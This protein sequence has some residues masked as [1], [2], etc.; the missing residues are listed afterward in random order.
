MIS[1][2]LH[3]G[4]VWPLMSLFL[5]EQGV[6]EGEIGLISGA[7]A[8]APLLLWPAYTW[9]F[10]R[11][12]AVGTVALGTVLSLACIALFFWLG[13]GWWSFVFRFG[14]GVGR[15]L[16]WVATE[17]WVNHIAQNHDRGRAIA[18]YSSGWAVGMVVGPAL[19]SL[20]GD[21]GSLPVVACVISTL[22][23]VL[24]LLIFGR[25]YA[26]TL[27]HEDTPDQSNQQ[28]PTERAAK[29][30]HLADLV[31]LLRY[32]PV[33]FLAA[34]VAGTA[35]G[36]S[37]SLLPLYWIDQGLTTEQAAELQILFG[38]GGGAG[39]LLAGVMADRLG[40]RFLLVTPVIV[41]LASLLIIN[42]VALDP[43]LISLALLTLGGSVTS[44]YAIGLILLGD[45]FDR[46]DITPGNVA[47]VGIYNLGAIIG[48][49]FGGLAIN[50]FPQ[51]GLLV[52]LSAFYIILLVPALW[53]LRPVSLRH[54]FR[55]RVS[56][57]DPE[58]PDRPPD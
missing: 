14:V 28:T 23:P 57:I 9:F 26:P 53:Y 11:F 49:V 25:T 29:R 5:R 41:G 22:V 20:T 47:Y 39:I 8:I 37:F 32:A 58:R 27:M 36:Q 51:V 54:L 31:R 38:F 48:P 19:L 45:R 2:G 52:C 35:E 46:R 21:Q 40:R 33:I 12:G 17:A 30:A 44:L 42:W 55:S 4:Y 3:L 10:R 24:P 43:V 16:H 18:V 50:A 34:L 15:S 56:P 6:S 7:S 1:I 13:A